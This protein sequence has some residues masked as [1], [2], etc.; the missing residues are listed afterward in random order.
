[1]YEIFEKLL[2]TKGIS[3]YKFC[4]D[5]GIPQSTI[6]T[7]KTKG[8]IISSDL[9]KTIADYFGVSV[10]YLLTGKEK[11]QHY[12]FDEE[13]A[14]IAQEVFENKDLRLLFDASRNAKPEDIRLAAEMLMRLKEKEYYKE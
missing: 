14:K 4:K 2:K 5:T 1:M 10:D 3:T 8:S 6:S 12:Y 13:T 7:W 11:E 9:A